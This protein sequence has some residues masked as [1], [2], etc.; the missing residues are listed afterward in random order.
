LNHAGEFVDSWDI[1]TGLLKTVIYGAIIALTACRKGLLTSGGA[2]GVG[3]ACTAAVV[4]SSMAIIVATFVL[5]L[6]L[7]QLHGIFVG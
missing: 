1:L 3:D 2:T 5:T 4:S 6:M 7:Q